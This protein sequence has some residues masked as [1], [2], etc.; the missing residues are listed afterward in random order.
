M[1]REKTQPEREKKHGKRSVDLGEGEGN[2][3]D[4]KSDL[5]RMGKIEL[6]EGESDL[7]DRVL[8]RTKK[9]KKSKWSVLNKRKGTHWGD[10]Q[11]DC[12][13]ERVNKKKHKYSTHLWKKASHP[14][15]WRPQT[16]AGKFTCID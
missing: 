10:Q 14:E 16:D 2:L 3:E 15:H 4:W 5:G 6:G 12:L 8:V 9:K 1:K 11:Q 7:G 13:L